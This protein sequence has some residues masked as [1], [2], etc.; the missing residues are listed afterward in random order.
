MCC[1]AVLCCA[2][3]DEWPEDPSAVS[4]IRCDFSSDPAIGDR[5]Q[6]LVFIGQVGA[7]HVGSGIHILRP[8]VCSKRSCSRRF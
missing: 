1:H 2:V 4:Q 7:T 5:R 6:E 8:S 3:Q